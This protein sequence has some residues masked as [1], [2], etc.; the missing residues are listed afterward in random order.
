MAADGGNDQQGLGGRRNEQDRAA[1]KSTVHNSQ[2]HHESQMNLD[3]NPGRNDESTAERAG[4]QQAADENR[5]VCYSDPLGETPKT[6]LK[7]WLWN[8]LFSSRDR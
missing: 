5:V 8:K 6:G 7:E 2:C 3:M 4:N 1:C